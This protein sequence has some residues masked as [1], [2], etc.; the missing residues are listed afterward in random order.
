MSD[1][2]KLLKERDGFVES[3]TRFLNLHRAGTIDELRVRFDL[4]LQHRRPIDEWIEIALM[5]K[6]KSLELDFVPCRSSHRRGSGNYRFGWKFFKLSGIRFLIS[7]CLKHVDVSGQ[8]LESFLSKCPLLETLHVSHSKQLTRLTVWGSSLRLKH[9]HISFCKCIKSIEVYATNLVTFEYRGSRC[10]HIDLKCVPQL[11]D[12]SYAGQWESIR[13]FHLY[14][15]VP[16]F[17]PTSQLVNLSL[18][19]PYLP[20]MDISQVQPNFPNL[21]YLSLEVWNLHLRIDRTAE[22]VKLCHMMKHMPLL[23]KFKVELYAVEAHRLI[24]EKYVQSI[25]KEGQLLSL[26][27]EKRMMLQEVEIAGFVGAAGDSVLVYFLSLIAPNLDSIVINR[28]LPRWY[29]GAPLKERKI[30]ELGDARRFAYDMLSANRP[31]GAKFLLL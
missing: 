13:V 2:K 6:V 19:I 1:P 5:K 28:C 3:I 4:N 18:H 31:E 25:I 7:L 14:E 10:V 29:C 24:E 23:H 20:L 11:C 8:V 27:H 30:K 22:L 15:P 21:L 9:L 26:V 17:L 16:S 12:V